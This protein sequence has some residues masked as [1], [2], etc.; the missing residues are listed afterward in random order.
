MGEMRDSDWSRANLLR[1]DWLL[2]SVA[3]MTTNR[4]SVSEWAAKYRGRREERENEG[5]NGYPFPLN[6]LSWPFLPFPQQ[7]ALIVICYLYIEISEE[8][9]STH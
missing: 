5:R 1:S 4:F 8:E 2:P 9:R 7:G 3:I 6:V